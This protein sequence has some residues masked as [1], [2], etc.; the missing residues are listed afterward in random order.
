[1]YPHELG[2]DIKC[3]LLFVDS[4]NQSNDVYQWVRTQAPQ[5]VMAIKGT[6]GRLPVAQPSPVDVTIAGGDQARP[7]I[8]GIVVPFFKSELYADLKKEAPTESRLPAAGATRWVLPLSP[9]TRNYGDEH[10]P[11]LCAEQ[12]VTT[13]DRK[14]GRGR[15]A[16]GSRSRR[17][18]KGW[19]CRV[20][21]RA[22]AWELGID[23][24]RSELARSALL[25]WPETVYRSMADLMRP[26]R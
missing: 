21:A 25:R 8:H 1:V 3:S 6:K 18:M 26:R 2:G 16:S 17:A 24:F 19:I 13:R 10:F 12:L 9:P 15:N 23:R 11:Q 7:A 4:G 14:T 22:A 20:Y 5:R